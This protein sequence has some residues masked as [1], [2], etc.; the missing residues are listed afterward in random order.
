MALAERDSAAGRGISSGLVALLAIVAGVSVANLYY[1]Q[2]LLPVLSRVFAVGPAGVGA[3]AVLTQVGYALGL[4]LFIPLGD[5]VERKALILRLCA[6][7]VLALLAL[8]ASP[9]LAWLGTASLLVGLC[10]V[11]PHVALPLAAHL[12]GPAERGRVIGSVLSGLLIGI[13]GARTVSGL[14]AQALGWRAVYLA[15][16]GAMA[17]LG[18]ALR[19]FLPHQPPLSPLPYAVL[20]GSLR[21]L[22][23]EHRDLRVASLLGAAGM[24]AFSVLWVTLAF[25]LAGPAFGLGSGVAGLFGLVG[26]A[27]ALAAPLVGR[28]ADRRGAR[29]TSGLALALVLASWGIFWSLGSSLAGL[30]TGVLL[31]DVGVQSNQVSNLARVHS[32]DPAARSRLNTVYMVTYFAGAAAGTWS[33]ARAWAAWGWPGACLAGAAFA[34][35]GLLVWLADAASS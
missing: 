5:A 11:V 26:A 29:V 6:S 25:H 34:G 18:L 4:L 31:L 23:A 28:V 14:L 21:T 2:P 8:A 20:L 10:S 16:A 3:V 22:V 9:T 35:A 30:V 7:S 33:G 1:V 24:G 17:A 15:A 27:G 13:L 32:L 12:A 19:R